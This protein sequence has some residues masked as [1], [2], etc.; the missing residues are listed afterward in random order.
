MMKSTL[1]GAVA[2]VA[3]LAL[4][5]AA[6]LAQNETVP[7][8]TTTAPAPPPATTAPDPASPAPPPA[9][10]DPAIPPVTGTETIVTTTTEPPPEIV[11]PPLEP[12]NPYANS[13]NEL[14]PLMVEEDRGFDD[15]GLLGLLGLLGLIGLTGRRERIIY[16]ERD[17]TRVYRAPRDDLPPR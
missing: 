1:A 16:V 6:G 2:A 8:N 5:P 17:E 12:V 15:W 11:L 9:E 7:A 4:S 14:E 13:Y 10:A 3:V